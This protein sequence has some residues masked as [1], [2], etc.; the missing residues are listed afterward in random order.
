MTKLGITGGIGSGKSIVSTYLQ[1]TGIPVYYCDNEA[2]RLMIEDKK[3]IDSIQRILGHE[4]YK[5]GSLNRAFVAQQIFT[6]PNLLK[7]MNAIVHPAVIADFERWSLHQHLPLVAMETAIL[8]ESQFDRAV[9]Y[10]IHVSANLETRIQR[11]IQRDKTSRSAVE[12]RI[13][14]QMNEAELARLSH[15]VIDNNDEIPLTPQIEKIL[16]QLIK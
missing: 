8:F 13:K 14:N 10:I 12:S 16:S 4:A 2:K 3:M 1:H 6:D 5:E 15:F 7:Q 9:D 11:T